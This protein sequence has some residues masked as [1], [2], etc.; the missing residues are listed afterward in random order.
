MGVSLSSVEYSPPPPPPPRAGGARG[1]ARGA[2]GRRRGEQ[3]RARRRWALRGQADDAGLP[4]RRGAILHRPVVSLVRRGERDS[5]A[6][7]ALQYLFQRCFVRLARGE[8]RDRLRRDGTTAPS[9]L[10]P[11][12]EAAH[13]RVVQDLSANAHVLRYVYADL[14]YSRARDASSPP[15]SDAP[16]LAFPLGEAAKVGT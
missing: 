12:E 3:G 7:G 5:E 1:A 11:G 9:L 4:E 2:R 15:A 16:L 8:G 10:R 14:T 13:E 6:S